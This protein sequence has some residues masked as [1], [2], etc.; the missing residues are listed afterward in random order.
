MLEIAY[1]Y[2]IYIIVNKPQ[3]LPT[4]NSE[5]SSKAS[6]YSLLQEML[7]QRNNQETY[8][9]LHHR[10]DAATSGL[11]LFCKRK[12]YNRYTTDLFRDKKI[13]KTYIALSQILK[14]QELSEAWEVNNKLKTYKIRHFKKSK[15]ANKGESAITSFKLLKKNSDY[16]LV[17]CRPHTGRL[18][19]IRVHLSEYGL[20][21]LGDFHYHPSKQKGELML[22]AIQMSFKHPVTQDTVRVVSGIPDYFQKRVD[23]LFV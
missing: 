4:Q 12:E 2:D 7:N 16:V 6:L 9:A 15:S 18:H 1:E 20:P 17:E 3:G 8:L 10:L 21:I 22:H 19:Q 11:V 13:A 5:N 14:K 23:E